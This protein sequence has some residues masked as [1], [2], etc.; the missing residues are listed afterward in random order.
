MDRRRVRWNALTKIRQWEFA[1][2]IEFSTPLRRGRQSTLVVRLGTRLESPPL[3]T[4]DRGVNDAGALERE[5]KSGLQNL[6]TVPNA[7]AEIDGRCFLEIFRRTGNLADA[8]AEVDA[9]REHLV[10]KNEVIAIFPE[11]QAGEAFPGE[12]TV[13][14]VIL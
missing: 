1:V 2:W 5:L 9:L 13:P 11:R 6:E 4:E 3:F 10:V 8:K 14:G 12:G 7:A